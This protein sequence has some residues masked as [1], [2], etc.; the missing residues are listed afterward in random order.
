M[1]HNLKIINFSEKLA[2]R[3]AQGGSDLNVFEHICHT[4]S[5]EYTHII[6]GFNSLTLDHTCEYTINIIN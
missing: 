4:L 5:L 1:L 2:P 6:K 3:L